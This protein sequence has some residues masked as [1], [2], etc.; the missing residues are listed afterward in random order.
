MAQIQEP[1]PS[2]PQDES[3][4]RPLPLEGIRV[5]DFT[6]IVAGPRRLGSWR[7]SAPK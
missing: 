7:I 5:V 4:G 1:G 2:K 6:W 3:R